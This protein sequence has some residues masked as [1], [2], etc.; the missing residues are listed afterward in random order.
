MEEANRY[1]EEFNFALLEMMYKRGS[2]KFKKKLNDL[3]EESFD[4]LGDRE[5]YILDK[6]IVDRM[7]L[8]EIG[9][10]L[11]LSPN[12]IRQLERQGILGVS[13]KFATHLALESVDYGPIISL[14][15]ER[16]TKIEDMNLSTRLYNC[17]YRA[18]IRT[19][20]D[21]LRAV[22]R[23]EISKIENLGAQCLS[24]LREKLISCG[25]DESFVNLYLNS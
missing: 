25:I 2:S 5:K 21:I 11:D 1:N 23:R 3:I 14:L 19:M 18:D 15:C 16:V 6:R 24:E 8:R 9:K 12:R 17:L 7:T 10:T 22:I 13:N 4:S 20:E